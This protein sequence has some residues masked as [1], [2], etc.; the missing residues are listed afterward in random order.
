[1]NFHYDSVCNCI[2][3]YHWDTISKIHIISSYI[4]DTICVYNRNINEVIEYDGFR[5]AIDSGVS[6]YI[7][8]FREGSWLEKWENGVIKTEGNYNRGLKSGIWYYY[9]KYGV[10]INEITYPFTSMP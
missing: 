7:G 8:Y 1:M 5:S 6:R 3:K 9:D 10:K 4:Y 2:K